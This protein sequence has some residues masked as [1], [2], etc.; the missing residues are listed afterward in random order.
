MKNELVYIFGHKN[1]DTDSVCA[2]IAL[3]YLKNRLGMNS[4]PAVLDNI[5]AETKYALDYF[6]VKEPYHLNDVKLQIKDVDYHRNNYIDKNT[7]IKDA[8]NYINKYNLTGIP[9][10]EGKRKYYGYVSLKEISQE[11]ING[12]FH[13]VD[14]SYGN[15]LDMLKG[16]KVLK[17]DKEIIGNVIDFTDVHDTFIGKVKVNNDDIVLVGDSETIM[18]YAIDS[19]VKLII[20]VSGASI[21][22]TLLA[23]AH[24]NKVNIISTKL[25]SY[26]TGKLVSLSNYIK[27]IVRKPEDT[28]TFNEIDF[29]S[30]F[31]EK[32]KQYRHTNYPILN[33]R[34]ECL[35]V[36]NITDTNHVKRKQVILVDHN[37]FNQSVVG[38]EEAEILEIIDHHNLGDIIT[39]KPINFRSSS[40]GCVSTIIYEMFNE[41]RIKVPSDIAG[42]LASAII[43]DTLLL[44]SPT[45]TLRDEEALN[46]LSEIAG[47]NYK[48]Y[49]MNLLK[50]G[51]SVTD[52]KVEDLVYGDFK[53]YKVEDNLLGIG[54][55]L[56]S[57]YSSIRKRLQEIVEFLNIESRREKYKVL[58]L[59]VTDVF[60][61][62]SYCFYNS[63]AEEIIRT[64]FN[65]EKVFEGI[66]L[67]GVLSRKV[68]IAPYLM[69]TLSR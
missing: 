43:S 47:I 41:S 35:G 63:D 21:D 62:K 64:S 7:T 45:T 33:S 40:C 25:D 52:L 37:N 14:T 22:K 50:K 19:K 32:S 61:K 46:R 23:E 58:T 54:Q 34:K 10:I 12:D 16:T 39:S 18:K 13:K 67:E 30:D 36:L 26:E 3:S 44:T 15:L 65:L 17:F 59:F 68:Q 28:I 2:A 1:P 8:F 29:L 6:K 42:L 53:S 11:V 20:V 69:E 57:D 31:F 4:I 51:M 60:S 24:K 55:V 66:V 27:S 38:L 48:E 9:V 49:G 5:N 56:I